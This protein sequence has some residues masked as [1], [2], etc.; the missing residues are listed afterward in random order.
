[1]ITLRNKLYESLLDDEE[2]LVKD[3]TSILLNGPNSLVQKTYLS[4][5]HAWQKINSANSDP[6]LEKNTLVYPYNILIKNN[7]NSNL[8]K[9][10]GV[11]KIDAKTIYLDDNMV[12]YDG[13]KY[14]K[15]FSIDDISINANVKSISNVD[16]KFKTKSENYNPR[17][18][19]IGADLN[20]MS[21]FRFSNVT[22]SGDH[23][24]II[25]RR[26]KFPEFKNVTFKSKYDN[27]IYFDSHNFGYKND[28]YTK[29]FNSLLDPKFK[30]KVFDH[31]INQYV[32]R[33]NNIKS[34]SS[35]LK[36][37]KFE[38]L[39][40]VIKF[41]QNTTIHDIMGTAVPDEIDCICITGYSFNLYFYKTNFDITTRLRQRQRHAIA[42]LDSKWVIAIDADKV[43]NRKYE[44]YSIKT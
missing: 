35:T 7:P 22:F 44:N 2:D 36:D 43:Q 14:C 20:D 23:I 42:K 25:S 19:F 15:E 40:D 1:M 11:D 27:I 21:R 24:L 3:D 5:P 12:E 33:P 4:Q 37:L 39:G 38:I 26:N 30:H 10:I 31:S 29:E 41:N 16:F 9:L 18:I 17:N 8:K 32:D 34:I 13:N 28:G 6:K